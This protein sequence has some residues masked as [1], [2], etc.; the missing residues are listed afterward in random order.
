MPWGQFFLQFY[1]FSRKFQEVQGQS[2]PLAE[3]LLS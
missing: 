2:A 3:A 1:D